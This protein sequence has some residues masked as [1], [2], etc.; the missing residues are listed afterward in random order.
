MQRKSDPI[1]DR[2]IRGLVLAL[3]TRSIPTS[4]S[5]EGHVDH[6]SPAPW[7]KVTPADKTLQLGSDMKS[8]GNAYEVRYRI[9]KYLKEFYRERSVPRDVRIVVE[10]AH[11]GFWVHNGGHAYTSWRSYVKGNAAKIRRGQKAK[12]DTVE[13]EQIRRSMKLAIYQR[14]MKA[15]AAFLKREIRESLA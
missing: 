8:K 7:I 5:C 9:L 2:Q 10:R 13:T 4:G 11:T 12:T 6:G 14:E 15:F 3:N 1:I